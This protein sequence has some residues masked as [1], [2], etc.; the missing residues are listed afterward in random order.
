[1]LRVRYIFLTLAAVVC[2]T[3]QAQRHEIYDEQIRTLQVVANEDW[4][5]MPVM[6]LNEGFVDIDFDDLTHEYRRYIYKVEHCEADWKVS[7]EILKATMWL[8]LL[9][10]TPST[11]YRNRF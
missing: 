6:K 11:M 3:I 1:M 5:S 7:E 8:V 9:T 4:L 2:T 10:E